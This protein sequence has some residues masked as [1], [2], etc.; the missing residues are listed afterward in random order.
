MLLEAVGIVYLVIKGAFFASLLKV[1]LSSEA[2]K[3]RPFWMALI[4]TAGIAL[5]SY[6]YF[7]PLLVGPTM[8]RWEHWV[9]MSFVLAFAYY[10]TLAKFEEVPIIW[11][12][13]L[14]L[15]LGLIIF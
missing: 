2:M 15:G 10:W 1:H 3:E 5:L 13:T 11:W 12:P 14:I 6:I 8:V 9:G 7:N 4:Y